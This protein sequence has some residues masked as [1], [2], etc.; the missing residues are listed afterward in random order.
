MNKPWRVGSKLGRTLYLNDRCVGLVDQPALAELLVSCAN[1]VGAAVLLRE[2]HEEKVRSAEPDPGRQ[3]R[4]VREQRAYLDELETQLL[5]IHPELRRVELVLP[6]EAT[7]TLEGNPT[8]SEGLGGSRSSQA[9]RGSEEPAVSFEA[10]SERS[11]FSH[12]E[13]R[14]LIDQARPRPSEARQRIEPA[15]GENA[16]EL[17]EM[18]WWRKGETHSAICPCTECHAL[19]RQTVDVFP[20]TVGDPASRA[21]GEPTAIL[22]YDG[23]RIHLGLTFLRSVAGALLMDASKS[24]FERSLRVAAAAMNE[25]ERRMWLSH[26][27]ERATSAKETP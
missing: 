1:A 16:P 14:L 27:R 24:S 17:P 22:E 12:Q 10:E 23:V 2:A 15:M 4:T 20:F 21:R 19:P 26:E 11:R 8:P 7:K 18:A 25:I 3:L 13:V 9:G 6:A 5:E